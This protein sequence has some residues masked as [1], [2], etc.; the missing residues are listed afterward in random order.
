MLTFESSAAP[1]ITTATVA[2]SG[3]KKGDLLAVLDS[4]LADK[5]NEIA[6]RMTN[7]ADG[8]QFDASHGSR[9][10]GDT[11]TYGEALCAAEGVIRQ[12]GK[13]GPLADLMLLD[14][15]QIG[16]QFAANAEKA[17][18]ALLVLTDFISAY[19]A[20]FAIPEQS[21]E[22]LATY[23]LALIIDSLVVDKIAIGEMNYIGQELAV[24][25]GA[26]EPK[27]TAP[28][29]K[30]ASVSSSS[31]SGCPDPTKTPVSNVCEHCCLISPTYVSTDHV[32]TRRRRLQ[33]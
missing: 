32:R 15:D 25:Y 1:P 30:S 26:M 20:V 11:A 7:C 29:P 18:D 8:T 24:T 27:P 12:A 10:R 13:G 2:A 14:H 22:Q 3:H 16:I 19:G 6:H 4:D 31:S 28:T 9:R 17:K 33:L 23:I 21:M 5:I